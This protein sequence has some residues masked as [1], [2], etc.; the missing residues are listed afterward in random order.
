MKKT[1]NIP[2]TEICPMEVVSAICG[3][4]GVSTTKATW[5]DGGGGDYDI[6]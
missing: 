6:E 4:S 1:Y 5:T 3:T 2:A